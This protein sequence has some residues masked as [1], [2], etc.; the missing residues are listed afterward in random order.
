MPRLQAQFPDGAADIA[1]RFG[2][3]VKAL[4]LYESMGFLRPSRDGNGW[5]S[6]GQDDCERLHQVVA[7]RALGLSLADIAK[8]MHGGYGLGGVLAMQEQALVE[9]RAQA[10]VALA[11][12]RRARARLSLGETLNA[13]A[14]ADLVRHTK[15]A[16]MHWSPALVKLAK[17][18]FSDDQIRQL[19]SL[20]ADP[21]LA[22]AWGEIYD[23]L[24]TLTE[25][26]DP[27][28]PEALDVGRRAWAL[29]NR[30]SGDNTDT[31]Q[32]M[33]DFWAKGLRDPDAAGGLPMTPA[34][35]SFLGKI[36]SQLHKRKEA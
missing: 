31:R 24:A 32:A 30:M 14:L 26:G 29:I 8:L 27:A 12:V 23:Q 36:I 4:R 18:T 15:A 16:R 11:I 33:A 25:K 17:A 5:R 22:V 34:Q 9:Q 13:D 35:W 28:S 6:Y 21:D 7:L 20:G 1:R 3:T 10:E 19:S 2:L